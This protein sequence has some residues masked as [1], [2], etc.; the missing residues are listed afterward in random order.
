MI[1]SLDLRV[2]F[3]DIYPAFILVLQTIKTDLD[4]SFNPHVDTPGRVRA[5]VKQSAFWDNPPCK[6]YPPLSSVSG[7]TCQNPNPCYDPRCGHLVLR[8]FILRLS[9]V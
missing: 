9:K 6:K 3:T 7:F 2:K 4:L 8:L 5:M 1:Y